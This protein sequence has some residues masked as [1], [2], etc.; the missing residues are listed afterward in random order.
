MFVVKK[1]EKKRA[2]LHPVASGAVGTDL[3]PIRG[4][5]KSDG[6]NNEGCVQS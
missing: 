2:R 4:G 3:D 1:R 6:A 5:G